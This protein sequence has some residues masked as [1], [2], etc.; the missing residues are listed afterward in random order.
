MEYQSIFFK[1]SAL[2]GRAN[3]HFSLPLFKQETFF[4]EEFLKSFNMLSCLVNLQK[5]KYVVFPK[6]IYPLHF[7]FLSC[8]L[9]LFYLLTTTATN[10]GI[11]L[12]NATVISVVYLSLLIPTANSEFR[13]T[14]KGL[15]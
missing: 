1:I 4:T 6:G 2:K 7:L 14:N 10:F 12:G 5:G 9:L 3:D 15:Q 13:K 11:Q 8:C